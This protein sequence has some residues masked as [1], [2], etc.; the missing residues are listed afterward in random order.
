MSD[1]NSDRSKMNLYVNFFKTGILLPICS[2]LIMFLGGFL[3]II[4]YSF[5]TTV[6]F[7]MLYKAALWILITSFAL[8]YILNIFVIFNH[9]SKALK[10]W[11]LNLSRTYLYIA[12]ISSFGWYLHGWNYGI[13]HQGLSTT[14]ISASIS[15][16]W[17]LISFFKLHGPKHPQTNIELLKAN[18]FLFF[19]IYAFLFPW[20]GETP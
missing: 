12:A 2:F 20:L 6:L 5:P 16:I 11:K 10:P 4:P 15:T 14:I 9:D 7:L 17:I 18:A 1:L 3:R 8:F 13:K 19:G